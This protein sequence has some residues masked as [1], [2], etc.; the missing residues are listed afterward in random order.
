MRLFGLWFVAA[1]VLGVSVCSLLA[2]GPVE[3]QTP[4]KSDPTIDAL[5][6]LA[7]EQI[8][9]DAERERIASQERLAQEALKRSDAGQ[10]KPSAPTAEAPAPPL[11]IK[12][13]KTYDVVHSTLVKHIEDGV[14]GEMLAWC[15]L[16]GSLKVFYK[17]LIH[18]V[19]GPGGWT[20]KTACGGNGT[21]FYSCPGGQIKAFVIE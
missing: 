6:R 7:A 1:A 4:G 16:A 14:E 2:P 10:P 15:D 5:Q 13:P 9:A 11:M 17:G 18:T 19:A 12:G 8:R 20:A 21:V 3:A